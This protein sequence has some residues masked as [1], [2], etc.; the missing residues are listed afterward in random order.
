MLRCSE[1]ER[2]RDVQTPFSVASK[3]THGSRVQTPDHTRLMMSEGS[4][5]TFFN[6]AYES[7]ADR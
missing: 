6:A 7:F 4:N 3:T 5:R 1:T 2:Q